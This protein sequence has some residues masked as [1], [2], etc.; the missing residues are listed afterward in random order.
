MDR[1]N[2]NYGHCPTE[3]PPEASGTDSE[4]APGD[5]AIIKD[6]SLVPPG[7]GQSALNLPTAPPLDYD[8]EQDLNL[9]I[10]P[11]MPDPRFTIDSDEEGDLD[12][13]LVPPS[14]NDYLD[15]DI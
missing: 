8:E 9:P 12:L 10:L 15:I 14:D 1:I 5:R 2:D 3:N 6:P 11:P 13:P 4:N 7:P